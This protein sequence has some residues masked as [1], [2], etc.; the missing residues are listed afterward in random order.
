MLNRDQIMFYEENGY[1]VIEDAIAPEQLDALGRVTG[2]FIE[3]SRQLSGSDDVYDLDAGHS[4]AEPRLTRIKLPHLL[5]PIYW[6]TLSVAPMTAILTALLSPNVRLHTSKLNTKAPGGGAAVEWHQDWA[7]YPHTN[8]DLLAVGLMLEDVTE[9]NGALMVIPGSHKG[10][11]LDHTSSGVFCGAV[12]PADPLFD[13]ASAVTLTG[14]AGTISLHHVRTLH[15]SAP[16]M[17]DRARLLLFYECGAADAWPINGNSGPFTGMPQAAMWD[18]MQKRMICGSQPRAA[19][20][21]P[22]PVI[23]PVPPAPDSSSIFKV[24]KSGGAVSAF[25]DPRVA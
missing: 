25:C 19:R 23:M 3:R 7:F 11:V 24:Q 1:L 12:D 6:D 9:E 14:K 20:L 18:D 13:L 16:N 5:H 22:I 8:D 21:E 4:A 17:S 2:E 15:G 10:P